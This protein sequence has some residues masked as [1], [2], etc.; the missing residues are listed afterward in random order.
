MV[1]INQLLAEFEYAALH[2]G[3][4]VANWKKDTGRKAI[5]CLPIHIPEELVHAAAML[6]VGLWGGQ[7]MIS[8]ANEYLQAFCCSVAKAVME[9]ALNGVYQDLDAVVA[10]TTCDTMNCIA[11]NWRLAIPSIPLI[12]L[13]YP[14]NRKSE[15]GIQY[16]AAEFRRLANDLGRISGV[17]IHDD[18][19]QNSIDVY[20]RRRTAMKAF[21]NEAPDYGKIITPYN[22]HMVVKSSMFMPPETHLALLNDLTDELKK[23]PKSDAGLRRVVL[24]GIMPE[25]YDLLK[26]LEE[27]DFTIVADDMALGSRQYRKEAPPCADPYERLS[28]QFA[29]FEGCSTIYDPQK[30]RGKLLVDMAEHFRADVV[31]ILLMKFCDPEDFD[32]PFLKQDLEKAGIPNL[33]LEIEQQMQFLEQLRTSL[34]TF[35]EIL[36]MKRNRHDLTDVGRN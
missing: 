31:I 18:A 17:K 30:L 25:P 36:I 5:G 6:P 4:M 7:T 8:R 33:C 11:M 32:Y 23:L 22:R 19:L 13:A 10:P 21:L 34:Q 28:R 20:Q 9:F 12:A 16:L 26:I 27:L 3:K 29:D 1:K 15:S 24:T 35:S 2:P 14:D